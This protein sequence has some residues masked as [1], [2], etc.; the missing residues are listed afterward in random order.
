MNTESISS[1]SADVGGVELHYLTAGKGAA[2]ILLHGYA[3]TSMMWRRIIPTLAER[4]TVIAPDLP[5]IGDSS[6]PADG[7]DMSTAAT[8]IHALVAS[9][10]IRQAGGVGHDT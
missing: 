9:L 1:R 3:E 2:G 4:F 8:R 5:G 10:G 6:I 7:L